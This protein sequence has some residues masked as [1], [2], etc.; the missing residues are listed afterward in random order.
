LL[1]RILPCVNVNKT[2]V[3]W[4]EVTAEKPT[5]IL[6]HIS[7][8]RFF[9]IYASVLHFPPQHNGSCLRRQSLNYN[10]AMYGLWK[11]L[12]INSNFLG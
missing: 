11:V 12:G 5:S 3:A 9:W 7:L 2:L 4:A 6:K 1:I 10:N 8:K